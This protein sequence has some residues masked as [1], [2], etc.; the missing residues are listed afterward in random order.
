MVALTG[1]GEPGTLMGFPDFE[2]AETLGK[3]SENG[4]DQ[5]TASPHL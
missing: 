5:A 4:Q 2:L 3:S 1:E